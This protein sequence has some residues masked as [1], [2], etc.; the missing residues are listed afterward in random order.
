MRIWCQLPIKLPRDDPQYKAHYD[1]LEKHYNLVKNQDTEIVIKDVPTMDWTS[2]WQKYTGLCFFHNIAILKSTLAAE[3]EGF[4]GVSIACFG[5]PG[6]PEARQLLNIPVTGLGESSMHLASMMGTKF[7]IITRDIDHIALR[8]EHIIKYGMESK[9]IKRNP[10][11]ALT[12]PKE[13]LSKIQEDA[14]KGFSGDYTSLVE[15]FKKVA[16]GCIEDGAEVLIVGCGLLSPILMRAG[17][18]EVNGA[19]IVE[20]MQASLK[21]T[22]LLVALQKAKIPFV[23][24]KSS[25]IAVPGKYIAEVLAASNG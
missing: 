15:N 16:T 19:A 6:L 3:R 18:V 13:K 1:L 21:L 4:D 2:E 14:F 22:E 17:I 7:A 10:V 20:P 5:D 25:Y 23:S 9:A 12:L 24:R 11:R 8:E